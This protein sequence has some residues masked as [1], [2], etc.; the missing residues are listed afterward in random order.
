MRT[1]S[2]IR[3]L[4]RGS[5]VVFVASLAAACGSY[6]TTKVKNYRMHVVN[7]T[8]EQTETFKKLIDDFNALAGI[9]ALT[10]V[11]TAEEANSPILV[12]E[13]LKRSTGEMVGRG[14]WLADSEQESP[15]SSIDGS[16][17]RRTV[18]FSMRLE[19]DADYIRRHAADTD[20]DTYEKRKLFFHEVGHGMELDHSARPRDLMYEKIDGEKDDFGSFFDYVRSYMADT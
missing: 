8:A 7:G 11:D 9:T 5:L 18:R 15:L 16:R 20:T 12:V 6:E 13:G 4:A 19:F 2:F 17:P 10:Y 1:V 14:Q 3:A